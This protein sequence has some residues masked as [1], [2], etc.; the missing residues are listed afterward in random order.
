VTG[1]VAPR[2]GR[3]CIVVS[4]CLELAPVRYDGE[5]IASPIIRRLAHHVD[6]V[7]VCPEVGIH[8]GVP[9]DPILLVRAGGHVRLRQ[10]STGRDLTEPMDDFAED[11]LD[12]LGSADGFILKSRSPSCGIGDVKLLAGVEDDAVVLGMTSGRF[13]A[14]VLAR[15]PEAATEDEVGL[16]DLRRRHHWLTRVFTRATLRAVVESGRADALREFHAA[17]R[18]LLAAHDPSAADDLGRLV[19]GVDAV[20]FADVARAYARTVDRALRRPPTPPR[21][22]GLLDGWIAELGEDAPEVQ[23]CR[24]PYPASL[25]AADPAP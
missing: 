15:F 7:P 22:R 19:H 23:R 21:P 8:L 11:F 2:F 1:G 24:Q 3:P 18:L 9:R 20:R 13:A 25:L 4:Q 5:L 12:R 16:A 17:H 6:L 10:P 14:A